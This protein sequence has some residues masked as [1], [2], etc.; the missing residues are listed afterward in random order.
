MCIRDRPNNELAG[1]LG[2]VTPLV[3]PFVGQTYDWR[4]EQNGLTFGLTKSYSIELQ[5]EEWFTLA[6]KV[7]YHVFE[8]YESVEAGARLALTKWQLS[9]FVGVNYVD[10]D[11]D[12]QNFNF[13]TDEVDG[14]VIWTGGLS[15]NF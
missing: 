11:F 7:A 12:T 3:T 8:D 13:A 10:N 9:P 6:P 1:T 2:L 5:G 15:I 14:D 4:L